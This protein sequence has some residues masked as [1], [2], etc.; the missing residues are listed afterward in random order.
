MKQSQQLVLTPQLRQAIR[1]LQLSNLELSGF[2]ADER[3]RNPLVEIEEGAP[4]APTEAAEPETASESAEAPE[5]DAVAAENLFGDSPI[6]AQRPSLSGG[7]GGGGGAEGW[8]VDDRLAA[9]P[10]LREH[11]LAQIGQ[12]R[13]APVEC[14]LARLLIEML[15]EHG[16]LRAD[17]SELAGR[18]GVAPSRVD[19]ALA[20]VQA[21][22]PTGVGA[23]SLP[24]CLALQLAESGRLD[25][26]MR[27]VLDN[28]NLVARGEH[29][30]LRR[31]AGVGEA[32][33][34]AMLAE[35]RALD[36]RPCAG[37]G[38]DPAQTVVPDVFVART[39]W[40]GWHVELN[41]E[42][43]PRVLVD[44]RY[45]TELERGGEEA[46][47]FV[48]QCRAEAGW[49]LK[50]LDQRAR[51][52]LKVA[53]EIVRRQERFFDVGLPG[54]APLNLK[55]V[56]EATGI[57]ESTASRVTANKY[58][59]TERGVFELKFF[60]S[61]AVGGDAEGAVSALSVRHRIQTMV[62]A[63]TPDAVLSDD[64]IVEMLRSDGVGIARRTVAKYR[65]LL[66]IPSS[67]DRRRR[68]VL[69]GH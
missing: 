34:A 17:P 51:T 37:F 24:E 16:L 23:R 4:P 45:A 20:L 10:T 9:M 15:D 2:L 38:Q 28:L 50:S 30:R 26:A 14:H 22:E 8:P 31:M 60:F 56:A 7:S 55:M 3:E 65:K 18:L 67:V 52:I 42:T 69:A 27:V 53:T 64:S 63:E 58:M 49:L 43:L 29:P 68:R 62:A 25:P 61:N 39:A 1:L 13:A 33:Y 5:I 41:T 46:R 48:A 66:N 57:H 32:D 11:L 19:A 47:R 35:I 44:N 12:A 36:P 40:G 6:P 59:A 21:C 54:L